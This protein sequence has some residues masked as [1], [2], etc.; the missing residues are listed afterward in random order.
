MLYMLAIYVLEERKKVFVDGA[1]RE[2]TEQV[3]FFV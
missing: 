1:A 3:L 2:S